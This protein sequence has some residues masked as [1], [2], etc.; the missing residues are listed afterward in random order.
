MRLPHAGRAP[1]AP[2]LGETGEIPGARLRSR[3][4]TG[5]SAGA[6]A[7]R[8]EAPQEAVQEQFLDRE[9]TIRRVTLAGSAVN[10]LLVIFK[11]LAGILGNSSAMIADAV[12]SLSDFA[13]DVIVLLCLRVSS[14]PEDEDHTYGHGKFETLAAV[15]IGLLLLATGIGLCWDGLAAILEFARGGTLPA[16][17]WLAFAAAGLSILVKEGLYHYTMRAAR[18]LDS[19]TLRANAWHH[20]SD[21]LSSVATVIGIGAAMLPGETWRIADPLAACVISVFIILM[22]FSLMKPGI[23]EL[24]EKSLPEA[25]RALIAESIASTPGVLGYHRIRTRR[26]GVNRAVEAHIKLAPEMPLREAHDIATAI[27]RKIQKAL[28]E[29]THVGIHMEPVAGPGRFG[30]PS[31]ARAGAEHSQQE[32]P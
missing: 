6:P 17:S 9:N 19:A 22:A 14:K 12:H 10:L 13:S 26:M 16:P 2:A 32:R 8:R 25:E 21:A 24:M 5:H 11:F 28:G 29:N 1:N 30:Q 31:G 15:A 20:R 23:D 4:E 18:K 27:E 7:F 3:G